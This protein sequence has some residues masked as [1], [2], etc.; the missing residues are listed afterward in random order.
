MADA[1]AQSLSHHT[2]YDPLFHF[3]I[4]PVFVITL[5]ASV[6]HAIRRPGYILRGWLC[7]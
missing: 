3:F 2:R 1:S 6:A 4:L 5:I 7:S